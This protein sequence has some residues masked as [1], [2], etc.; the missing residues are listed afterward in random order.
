M[1]TY[2]ELSFDQH[3]SDFIENQIESGK[4]DSAADVLCAGLRLL[5]H[6]GSKLDNLRA[7]LKEGEQSGVSDYSYSTFLEMLDE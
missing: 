6:S 2:S 3:Y 5:E 1:S 7:L 4:F